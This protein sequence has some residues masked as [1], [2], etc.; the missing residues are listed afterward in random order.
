MATE[1][2]SLPKLFFDAVD[3]FKNPRAQMF[4]AANGWEAISANEMLRR[5]A[6]LSNALV[7]LGVQ[8]GD[9]VGLFAPNCPE[10]HIAGFAVPGI[11]AV[12]VPVYFNESAARLVQIVND[13]GAKV[14]F[15]CV[16]SEGRKI[17]ECRERLP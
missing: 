14:L 16:D 7:D 8:R 3:R 1:L 15:A 17:A 11:G 12:A 6:A 4:R 5:V 2:L 13:S 9:R 10:W